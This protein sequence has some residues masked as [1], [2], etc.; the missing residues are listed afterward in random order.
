MILS[1]PGRL[2]RIFRA[3]DLTVPHS[4]SFAG[5]QLVPIGMNMRL[6]NFRSPDL[7][8]EIEV[9]NK[10]T[11]HY[12]PC[13]IGGNPN[14]FNR[15]V[16]RSL[17]QPNKPHLDRFWLD[18]SPIIPKEQLLYKTGST[19]MCSGWGIHIVECL[20]RLTV[21]LLSIALLGVSGILGIV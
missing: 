18:L 1:W 14:E 13:P 3:I 20:N 6:W 7:A 17:L 10:R 5:F 16:I 8:P 2:L 9:I 15:E 4:T 19:E 21:V 11:Y 12:A